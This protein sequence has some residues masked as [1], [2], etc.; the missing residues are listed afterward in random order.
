MSDYTYIRGFVRP[1][2]RAGES[3][4]IEIA[5]DPIN[6]AES[7]CIINHSPTGFNWGYGGSGAAQTALAIIYHLTQDKD[8]SIALHQ[9]FK[10]HYITNLNQV[11]D[12]ELNVQEVE[13]WIKT[14]QPK[15]LPHE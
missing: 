6:P 9:E 5:G 11:E 3:R 15:G 13:A 10:R 1:T 8:L 2:G 7:Q 14:N 12:F 4:T